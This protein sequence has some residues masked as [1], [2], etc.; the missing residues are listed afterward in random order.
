MWERCRPPMAIVIIGIKGDK[1]GLPQIW[2]K[3]GLNNKNKSIS[4]LSNTLSLIFGKLAPLFR[5]VRATFP[6]FN[7]LCLYLLRRVGRLFAFR[8]TCFTTESVPTWRTLCKFLLNLGEMPQPRLIVIP[9]RSKRSEVSP[10]GGVY[11][12]F[13]LNWEEYRCRETL[14]SIEIQYG[15]EGLP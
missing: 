5:R 7:F 10:L 12:S 13:W 11:L 14:L 3:S 8:F 15:K 1:E 6:R 4:W 9:I 2:N